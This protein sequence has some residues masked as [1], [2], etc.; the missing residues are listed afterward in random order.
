MRYVHLLAIVSCILVLAALPS[1]A[2][3]QHERPAD[4]HAPIHIT[5]DTEFNATNGVSGG[6]GTPDDPY[7]IQNLEIDAAG[8]SFGI[9]IEFTS[10][11]FKIVNC[12]VHNAT[13]CVVAPFGCGIAL[14]AVSNATITNCT[15]YFNKYNGIWVRN[16]MNVSVTG[17]L[18]FNNTQN[19]IMVANSNLTVVSE[20]HVLENRECGILL[21]YSTDVIVENNTLESSDI[22]IA[23]DN[24]TYWVSNAIVNNSVNGKPVL[25]LNTVTDMNITGDYGQVIVANC[26]NIALTAL[27]I[28]NSSIGIQLGFS[29][30][31]VVSDTTLSENRLYGAYIYRCGALVVSRCTIYM[32]GKHGLFVEG[33][34]NIIIKQSNIEQNTEDGVRFVE[35]TNSAIVENWIVANGMYGVYITYNS[36]SNEIH[37][38]D[39]I[40]N[41]GAG[42][43]YN[44]THVQAYDSTGANT[45]SPDHYGNFWSDLTQPDADG[46]FVVDTPYVLDG[47]SGVNDEYPRTTSNYGIWIYHTPQKYVDENMQ[48]EIFVEVHTISPLSWI[49]VRYLPLSGVTWQEIT[50][51]QESG[52]ST[53]GKYTCTIPAQ[54]GTGYLKYYIVGNTSTTSINTPVYTCTV[55]NVV[56]LDAPQYIFLLLALIPLLAR[57][58]KRDN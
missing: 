16:S 42:S 15:V 41:N 4:I 46:D 9:Y 12:T 5:N 18:V 47:A 2:E 22:Q 54:N 34:D 35:T 40:D 19:G 52:N 49:K 32:N 37:H 55:G 13:R 11:H 25:F 29:G 39:F 3:A 36:I 44:T 38:N 8:E 50:M 56:E 26:T 53:D 7:I 6:S 27:S 51:T 23:G 30:N 43:S 58:S 20:N 14:N 1:N 33:S 45:W 48:I 21:H 28:T 10:V 17:N 57:F 24:V 31:V